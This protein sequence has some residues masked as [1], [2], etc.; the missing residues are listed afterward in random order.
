MKKGII[1]GA[2]IGGLTTA[3]A[4]AKKD[5]D[6]T[7]YEQADEI[8]EVGAGIWVAPNGLKIYEK[9]GIVQDII[10]A[11][12]MLEKIS[13]VDLHKK[14][15]SVVD[16]AKIRAKHKYSTLALHRAALQKILASFIPEGKIVLSKKFKSY[17][18]TDESIA[19]EFEDGSAAE[20]DFIINA[21]GLKSNARER[22]QPDSDLRY[23]GQT[24]WRFVTDFDLPKEVE[25][26]MYEI[27]G[28]EKGLRAAYS[29]INDTQVYC[30]ITHYQ[31]AGG[32]DNRQTL[33][34]DLLN[35]CADFPAIIK[36]LIS[37]C[38][39]NV[40]IRT[41][42]F[43]FKPISKWTDG[44]LVLIGDAAHATTPNLG[45]GACQAIEDAY[46]IAE[47][48]SR[49]NEIGEAFKNFQSKRIEKATAITNMSWQFAQLTNTTGLTKSLIKTVMWLTPE[50][51]S[52]KQ[53]DRIYS[54][55]Y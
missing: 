20:A 41:D 34:T 30:Y 25:A 52:E 11:G 21:A 16:G 43:D 19:A 10:S 44:R 35:L 39:E 54:L 2:G 18:Q 5:F 45:Q 51:I 9:L 12:K 29:K 31:P 46:V 3:I 48:L 49:T 36:D 27:W 42:L 38:D 15:M 8:R 40:I 13:V 26:E 33:K 6:I 53:L 1:I 55:D 28:N 47:E 23:S 4:L 37:S 24:C 17:Q 22:I 50:F 32:A 7:V 14:P